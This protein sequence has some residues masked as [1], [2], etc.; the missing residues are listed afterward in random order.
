MYCHYN[1]QTVEMY[2]S[3][4]VYPQWSGLAVTSTTS[5][6]NYLLDARFDF[7]FVFNLF[8]ILALGY[9]GLIKATVSAVEPGSMSCQLYVLLWV[10][11][12]MYFYFWRISDDD[13]AD[14]DDDDSVPACIS[15]KF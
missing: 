15:K 13:G 7:K 14:D 11:V 8:C 2:S 10:I 4:T 12:Y 9:V 5:W 3:H 6:Q 1:I